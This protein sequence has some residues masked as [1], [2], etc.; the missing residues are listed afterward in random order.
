MYF[1]NNIEQLRYTY[2]EKKRAQRRAAAR[3]GEGAQKLI[4][5]LLLFFVALY[6]CMYVFA[7]RCIH[8]YIDDWLVDLVI[9]VWRWL[10][11]HAHIVCIVG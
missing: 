1:Y 3:R 5:I 6:V 4:K 2:R 8:V 11:P 7:H 9:P 10:H